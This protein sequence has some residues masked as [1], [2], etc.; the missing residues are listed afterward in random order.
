MQEKGF[1]HAL[2]LVIA[3]ISIGVL[4]IYIRSNWLVTMSS[5]S[6]SS[7]KA[8]IKP[9]QKM[10]LVTNDNYGFSFE[11]PNDWT[12]CDGFKDKNIKKEIQLFPVK[13]GE[14]TGDS[15]FSSVTVSENVT[16]FDKWFKDEKEFNQEKQLE[17]IKLVNE[18]FDSG[19]LKASD[20]V[21]ST[22]KTNINGFP[23]YEQ[24]I[25]T[26]CPDSPTCHMLGW[27]A[28]YEKRVVIYNANKEIVL[29]FFVVTYSENDN[30]E[31]FSKIIQSL[32][33][34]Q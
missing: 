34:K 21:A 16:N 9:A 12:I 28:G 15:F 22:K 33:F 4:A 10:K 20:I 27:P 5:G 32:K 14:P 17:Y 13:Q 29:E 6:K 2:L 30:T 3:V 19:Y 7:N 26:T 8:H 24:L 11:Y 1:G 18:M 23:A 25:T 31:T